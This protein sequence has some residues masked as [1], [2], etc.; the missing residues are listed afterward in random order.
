M[1]LAD[2]PHGHSDSH[3]LRSPGM[4][5]WCRLCRYSASLPNTARWN[6]A[7]YR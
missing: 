2:G 7:G 3:Q 1:T 4:G 6:M 5:G